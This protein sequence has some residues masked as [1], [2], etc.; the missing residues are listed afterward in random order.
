MKTSLYPSKKNLCT[1]CIV[2]DI[3]KII[4]FQ[5]HLKYISNVILIY[6]NQIYF[7]KHIWNIFQWY[8][9]V[10]SWELIY[11]KYI[12]DQYI[13]FKYIQNTF[14]FKYIG[15]RCI[16]NTSNPNHWK[17]YSLNTFKMY[18]VWIH[19]SQIYLEYIWPDRTF[20]R[21]NYTL[22][23]KIGSYKF[24]HRDSAFRE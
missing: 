11:F 12:W 3:F 16:S 8:G 20:I 15:F 6:L 1:R 17:V 22:R 14:F 13:W 21:P 4:I 5:I 7:F 18:T 9:P 23:F 10:L 24:R 19:S 2:S